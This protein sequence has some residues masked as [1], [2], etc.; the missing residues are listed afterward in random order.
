MPERKYRGG[1]GY[2][3]S[4]SVSSDRLPLQ[5][6]TTYQNSATIWEASVQTIE[7]IGQQIPFEHSE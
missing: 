2:K 3:T 4:R 1:R 7:P 6:S 5:G